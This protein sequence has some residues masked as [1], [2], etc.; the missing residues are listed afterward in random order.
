MANPNRSADSAY[1]ASKQP[2]NIRGTREGRKNSRPSYSYRQTASD[3]AASSNKYYADNKPVAKPAPPPQ[4]TVT[5]EASAQTARKLVTAFASGATDV[6]VDVQESDLSRVR[7][8]IEMAVGQGKLTRE[9]SDS[10]AFNVIKPVEPEPAPEP[11]VEKPKKKRGRPKKKKAA[12]PVIE[13]AE[14]ILEPQASEEA[15]LL[16][17]AEGITEDDVAKA[18]GVDLNADDDSDD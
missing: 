18:F 10:V 7:T 11:I 3:V 15:E 17:M 16:D 2:L 9:Q 13:E 1:Y 4:K 5:V 6:I 14:S 8:S 12:E